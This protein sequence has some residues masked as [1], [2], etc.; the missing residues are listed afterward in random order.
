MV[1]P[2][3]LEQRCLPLLLLKPL[4][5]SMRVALVSCNGCCILVQP[6]S[7]YCSP[8]EAQPDARR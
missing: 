8:G 4:P 3:P 1:I 7:T 6:A 5:L 2:V